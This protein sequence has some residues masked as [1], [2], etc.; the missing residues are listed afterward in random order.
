MPDEIV[1][2]EYEDGT[3]SVGAPGRITTH[4]TPFRPKEDWI[5]VSDE[6]PKPFTSVLLWDKWRDFK[7]GYWDGQMEVWRIHGLDFCPQC[8]GYRKCC[9]ESARI[10]TSTKVYP[11]EYWM[12]LPGRPH[13]KP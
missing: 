9:G 11:P 8:L 13:V 2:E 7:I 1:V 10:A 12:D 5:K 3:W 4:W 6:L